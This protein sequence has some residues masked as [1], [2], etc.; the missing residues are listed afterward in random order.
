MIETAGSHLMAIELTMAVLL[1]PLISFVICLLISEAYAW[2]AS[3][4]GSFMMLVTFVVVLVLITQQWQQP[5][6][7]VDLKWFTLGADD[8]TVNLII[9]NTVLTMLVVVISI[10][11]LIHLF[12]IGYIAGDPNMRRYF[13]MLGFFT[14]SMIGIVISDSLLV[15]FIFWELVGFSSYMLI[16]HYN[17]KHEAAIAAKKAFVINR[18]ADL[19]YIIGMILIFA[20]TGSFTISEITQLED[21]HVRTVAGICLFIGVI[22]KSAQLPFFTWLA[23]AMHGP[24]PVS[25]LIHAATMV[26]AGVYMLV[27][28]FPFFD[29]TTL[30]LIA[31]IGSATALMGAAFAT[32]QYDIK[33]ILAYSTMSQLGLMIFA[34]GLAAPEA[35]FLHLITHGAFKACLFLGAGAII[36]AND[37]AQHQLQTEINSQDIRNMGGLRSKMP[38]T[39]ITFAIAIAALCGLPF[40][41]GFL[42]KEAIL[43]AAGRHADIPMSATLV[44]LL[45]SFLTALY[46]FRLIWYVFLRKTE[47]VLLSNITEAPVIMRLPLILLAGA[48]MWFVVSL[49]PLQADGWFI[50]EESEEIGL[51]IFSML[52]VLFGFLV[53]WMLY[54][55]LNRGI[56]KTLQHGFYIDQAYLS[57]VNAVIPFISRVSRNIDTRLLD[58][59]IHAVTY[60]HVT[61]GHVITWTDRYILDGFVHFTAGAI[62][63]VGRIFRSFQ[64]GK[65]QLYIFWSML[66]III[67]LIWSS[68]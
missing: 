23:D 54:A 2:I 31:V 12:S 16:G 13:A 27:R 22:G 59:S 30:T 67:F 61:A 35:A 50:K 21:V 18:L 33:R 40:F 57:F 9:S 11:L 63:G 52:A 34:I 17:E 51:A 41:S 29:Q 14:F 56:V 25:A 4:F 28:I 45:A 5:V 48:S 8:I 10:S 1:L 42:S 26:A 58:K 24:A 38:V 47:S 60:A 19:G 32:A 66:A 37:H 55:R 20:E 36:H 6:V 64:G 7:A 15:M 44:I 49:N 65:I 62:S 39:F 43:I 53:S 3:L 46:S 68:N